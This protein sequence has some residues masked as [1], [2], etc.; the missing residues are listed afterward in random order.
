MSMNKNRDSAKERIVIVTD[1]CVSAVSCPIKVEI[2]PF[3]RLELRPLL[4]SQSTHCFFQHKNTNRET[5]AERTVIVTHKYWSA[6]NCPIEDGIVPFSWLMSRRL[7][8]SQSKHCCNQHTNTNRETA[9]TRELLSS[10]T[11]P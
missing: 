1:N 11:I 4:I 10:L 5:N 9:Q 2:V 6:V 7:L 8:L 3:S